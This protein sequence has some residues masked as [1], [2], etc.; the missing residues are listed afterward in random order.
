MSVTMQQRDL[1]ERLEGEQL[2]LRQPLLREG[3]VHPCGRL[4]AA[5]ATGGIRGGDHVASRR[6]ES[7]RSEA[8]AAAKRIASGDA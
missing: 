7:G 4:A 6:G 3:A 8:S 5:A 2:G 1:A